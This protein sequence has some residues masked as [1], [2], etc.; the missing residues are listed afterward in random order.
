MPDVRASAVPRLVLVADAFASGRD[1]MTA[2]DVQRRTVE[3]AGAGVPGVML[4]DHAAT[5]A[6]FARSARALVRD[7]RSA[8]PDVWIVVNARLDVAE[9]LGTGVHVGVRGPSVFE[10]RTRGVS[11]V[12]YSAHSAT[13]A[14]AAAKAG[15]AYV[16][17]SPVFETRT[18]PEAV[19]SGLDPLALAARTAGI[20]VLALGGLTPPRARLA[21]MVG[22]HGVAV[23]SNLLF[24]WDAPKTACAFLDAVEA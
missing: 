11:C 15:A 14:R 23:L 2:A 6:D 10:A 1:E 19:P 3:L 20:P 21:R 22:A 18:H 12:G 17:F 16:T 13:Q 24:A 5:D 8:N 9:T 4:R 7:L